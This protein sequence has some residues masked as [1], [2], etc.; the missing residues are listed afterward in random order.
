MVK[1]GANFAIERHIKLQEWRKNVIHKNGF[2]GIILDRMAYICPYHDTPYIMMIVRT[3]QPIASNMLRPEIRFTNDEWKT[4]QIEHGE[5]LQNRV[6]SHESVEYEFEF[7]FPLKKQQGKCT[8]QEK[9]YWFAVMQATNTGHQIW[10]NNEGWNYSVDEEYHFIPIFH[11]GKCYFMHRDWF[12][13][14]EDW[15]KDSKEEKEKE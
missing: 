4:L 6:I 12:P 9:G 11:V 14:I 2:W 3:S 5:P 1:N 10:D 13:E 7:I 15:K 8:W